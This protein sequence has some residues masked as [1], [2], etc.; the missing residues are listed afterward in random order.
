LVVRL[1]AARH[2]DVVAG[3]VLVDP[4]PEG[5]QRRIGRLDWRSSILGC[6]VRAA[7][8][9][10]Q[11]LGLRRLARDLGLTHEPDR[12]VA[13][14]YPSDLQ[15]GGLTLALSSRHRRTVVQELLALSRSATETHMQ[16]ATLGELPVTVLSGG[17]RGRERWYPIWAAMQEEL[18]R[19]LSTRSRHVVAGHTG[20]HVHLDDPELV[21]RVIREQLMRLEP[22][23]R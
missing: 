5:Y 19:R 17:E 15:A 11:P 14:D 6:W 8:L 16:A 4:T 10:L 3:M 22:Q 12:A 7:R 9:R 23:V 18:A 20:H 2:P 1:Y 13:R 21:V